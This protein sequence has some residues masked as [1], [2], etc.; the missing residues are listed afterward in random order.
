MDDIDL[1]QVHQLLALANIV[2]SQE[3]SGQQEGLSSA[4]ITQGPVVGLI[5]R[6]L[7]SRGNNLAGRGRV[8]SGM[9]ALGFS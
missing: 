3:T 2:K 6:G 8:G 1:R 5:D 4:R 7:S 9:A